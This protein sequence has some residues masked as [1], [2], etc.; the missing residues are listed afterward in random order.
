MLPPN[1]VPH[2]SIPEEEAHHSAS[3]AL[4]T[5]LTEESKARTRLWASIELLIETCIPVIRHAYQEAKENKR[6]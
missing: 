4:L 2:G 5:Q 6:R 3:T 1:P